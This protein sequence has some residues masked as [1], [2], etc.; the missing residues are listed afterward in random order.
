MRTK[1]S[2]RE[3]WVLEVQDPILAH[4]DRRRNVKEYVHYNGHEDFA[5]FDHLSREEIEGAMEFP[6]YEAAWRYV[7]DLKGFG[8][9][10]KPV[11]VVVKTS[12]T[13]AV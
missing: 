9:V 2:S 3:V 4:G 11:R 6:T 13:F 5:M 7:R 1:K 12:Y 8:Y 10:V